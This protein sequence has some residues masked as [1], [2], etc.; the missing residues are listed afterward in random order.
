MI[1]PVSLQEMKS[2][3]ASTPA[4]S[5]PL[6]NVSFRGEPEEDTV[7]IKG[8]TKEAEKTKKL[9]A[10]DIRKKSEEFSESVD[11]FADNIDKTTDSVTNA[12]TKTTGAVTLIGG[13]FAKLIPAPIKDF[14]ATPVVKEITEEGEKIFAT[15]KGSD[16]VERIVRTW[17][18]KNTAIAAGVAAA[19]GITIAVVNHFKNKAKQAEKAQKA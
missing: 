6:K 11:A 8:E 3:P 1:N 15:K 7:E 18:K 17:N 12:A 19:I 14:F 5:T 10:E 2:T 9:S 16:G 4:V 13:A